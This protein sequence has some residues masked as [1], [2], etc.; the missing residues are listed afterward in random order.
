MAATAI[1]TAS[2]RDRRATGVA[3]KTGSAGRSSLAWPGRSLGEGAHVGGT[4]AQADNAGGAPPSGACS[5]W[6]S[7]PSSSSEAQAWA[8]EHPRS[9]TPGHVY[10]DATRTEVLGNPWQSLLGDLTIVPGESGYR[11][12][13][14]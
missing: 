1:L 10:F 13:A 4:V 14:R 2:E 7:S 6:E 11:Q 12:A 8:R 3:T 9:V 5:S